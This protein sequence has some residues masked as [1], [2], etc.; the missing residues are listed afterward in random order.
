MQIKEKINSPPL[1]ITPLMF[2]NNSPHKSHGT[3]FA[4]LLSAVFT[5]FKVSCSDGRLKLSLVEL[6]RLRLIFRI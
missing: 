4:C 1:Q 6:V 3:G 5:A 2:F